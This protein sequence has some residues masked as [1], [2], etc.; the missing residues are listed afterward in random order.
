MINDVDEATQVCVTCP[1]IHRE[2]RRNALSKRFDGKESTDVD[3]LVEVV[4]SEDEK[5]SAD[6]SDKKESQEDITKDIYAVS[7]DCDNFSTRFGFDQLPISYS[8]YE[9]LE[10]VDTIV[11]DTNENRN[12]QPKV[13]SMDW[14]PTHSPEDIYCTIDNSSSS[15]QNESFVSSQQ[16][17]G[18][19]LNKMRNLHKLKT[20]NCSYRDN[21]SHPY[22]TDEMFDTLS[23]STNTVLS[24]ETNT[25]QHFQPSAFDPF[26]DEPNSII[27]KEKILED[28]ISMGEESQGGFSSIFDRITASFDRVDDVNTS[29]THYSRE[30][31]KPRNHIR[32]MNKTSTMDNLWL[33]KTLKIADEDAYIFSPRRRARTRLENEMEVYQS[34]SS[35]YGISKKTL[36]K[37]DKKKEKSMWTESISNRSTK[38]TARTKPCPEAFTDLNSYSMNV[39][40]SVPQNTFDKKTELTVRSSSVVAPNTTHTIKMEEAPILRDEK[41]KYEQSK[42]HDDTYNESEDEHLLTLLSRFESI[43]AQIAQLDNLAAIHE[44]NQKAANSY[45]SPVLQDLSNIKTVGKNV[46]DQKEHVSK[47]QV[48]DAAPVSDDI[49]LDS[50]FSSLET[51]VSAIEEVER[52][53]QEE[54]VRI[55]KLKIVSM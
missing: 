30:I 43:A 48:T 18:K 34:L 49:P 22:F 10:K 55:R 40:R 12:E 41:T 5:S 8:D 39:Q 26:G 51:L 27:V 4:I 28:E 20:A 21:T 37:E 6:T 23:P 31:E 11:L 25:N 24:L 46:E 36:S 47:E 19:D 14:Q 2:A 15:S 32:D 54:K 33:S 9:V 29:P 35:K 44:R 42:S 1:L 7:D 17:Q 52:N 3:C 13:Q 16:S 53:V 45:K 50:L 38:S